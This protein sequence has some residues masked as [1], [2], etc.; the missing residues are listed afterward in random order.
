MVHLKKLLLLTGFLLSS[1]F[2]ICQ[3][4]KIEGTWEGNLDETQFLQ[5]NIVQNGLA[6]CGYSFD[7]VFERPNDFCKQY[8]S[9]KYVSGDGSW[10][11]DGYSFMEDHYGHSLMQFKV[12]LVKENGKQY[13]EGYLRTKS[14][15]FGMPSKIRLKKVDPKPQMYTQDMKDCMKEREAIIAA[16]K[17]EPKITPRPAVGKKPDEKPATIKKPAVKPK[18]IA[19]PVAPKPK[20]PAPA[21]PKVPIVTKPKDTVAKAKPVVITAPKPVLIENKL[22]KQL[23]GRDNKE[24][25]RIQLKDKKFTIEVYDNGTV[26]DDTV[27]I[28]YNGKA[29]FSKKKISVVPLKYEVNLEDGKKLHNIVLFAENLGSI[30]PNTALV[31]ITTSSG[32]RYELFASSNLKE[33][34]EII[35]E[36]APE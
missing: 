31:I 22:E 5:V 8:Y 1:Y 27:S 6:L 23:L 13:L 12:K 15:G 10:F 17:K 25:K 28:F 33:N 32:K 16:A 3:T 34:A 30:P 36:Y 7:Y 4:D 9:G 24:F 2:A 14:G 20:L 18:V 26:D 21:K 35:F 29:I 19:P 11:F